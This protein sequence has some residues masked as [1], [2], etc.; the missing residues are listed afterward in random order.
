MT[1][2]QIATAVYILYIIGVLIFLAYKLWKEDYTEQSLNILTW[3]IVVTLFEVV[4][5]VYMNEVYN[6]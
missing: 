1:D 5:Q 2:V 6:V 3:I 4:I